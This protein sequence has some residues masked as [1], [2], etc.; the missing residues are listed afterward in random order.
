[1]NKDITLRDYFA[2]QVLQGLLA[3]AH[4]QKEFLKDIKNILKDITGGEEAKNISTSEYLQYHHSMVSYA[5][6]DAMLKEKENK[7]PTA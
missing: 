7:S 4:L 6:A 5:F 2:G 3:N 1:M